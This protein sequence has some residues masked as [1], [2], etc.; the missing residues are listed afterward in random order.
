MSGASNALVS[1]KFIILI[2]TGVV[3]TVPIVANRVGR[4]NLIQKVAFQAQ[5]LSEC[6]QIADPLTPII[7]GL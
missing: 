4:L 3:Y 1:L 2:S 6:M 5:L 7:T